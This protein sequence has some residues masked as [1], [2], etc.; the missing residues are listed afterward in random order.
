MKGFLRRFFNL[1]DYEKIMI[2]LEFFKLILDFHFQ[3][4]KK[5]ILLNFQ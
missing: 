1:R 5:Q 4:Q 3:L 2:F